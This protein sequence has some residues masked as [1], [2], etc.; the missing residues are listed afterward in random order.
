M[1]CKL[2]AGYPESK[3]CLPKHRALSSYFKFEY[4]DQKYLIHE[5][6]E[7]DGGSTPRIL[8]PIIPGGYDSQLEIPALVHDYFYRFNV[9]CNITQKEADKLMYEMCLQFGMS[10]WKAAAI[11]RAL[12]CFGHKSFNKWTEM[13]YEYEIEFYDWYSGTLEE[14]LQFRLIEAHG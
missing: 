3:I 5:G 7:W 6:F 12:K 8:R 11:H 2:Y 14:Y 13:H 1:Y 10:R 4:N 9:I